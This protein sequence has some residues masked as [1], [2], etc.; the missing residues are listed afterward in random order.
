M[1]YHSVKPVFG[2]ANAADAL[3]QHDLDAVILFVPLHY[4]LM[5]EITETID[6][7]LIPIEHDKIGPI[8]DRNHFLKSTTIPAGTYRGQ[9][10]DILTLGV[11]ILL[12]CRQNLTE[13]LVFALSKTLFEASDD[14]VRAHPAASAIDPERGPTTSITLHPGAARYYRSRQLPK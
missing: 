14:L 2:S 13:G 7:R 5:R 11:D 3:R 6:V 4:W 9:E 10:D 12:V 1:D 8:Q